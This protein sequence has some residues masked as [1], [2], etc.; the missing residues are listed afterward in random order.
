MD[1]AKILMRDGERVYRTHA[2]ISSSLKSSAPVIDPVVK[3]RAVDYRQIGHAVY[4]QA[5]MNVVIFEVVDP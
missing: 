2:P 5:G 1:Q 3:L 4:Q